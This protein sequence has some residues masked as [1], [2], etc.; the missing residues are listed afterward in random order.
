MK[1]NSIY[2]FRSFSLSILAFALFSFQIAMAQSDLE[3]VS[4]TYAVAEADSDTA[5]LQIV[6][7][8]ENGWYL[9][10]Q[11][12]EDGGPVPTSFS[13][14]EQDGLTI[15]ETI[16]EVGEAKAGFDALFEMEIVKFADSVM[17][18]VPLHYRD[19]LE[20][21]TGSLRFMCCDDTRCLPPETVEFTVELP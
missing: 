16:E 20:K 19:E 15:G 21:L 9:Y 5:Q 12:I 2:M 8:I 18:Q 7:T 11:F 3:P 4:W 10:S 14:D 13:F 17:F 1:F 6:A